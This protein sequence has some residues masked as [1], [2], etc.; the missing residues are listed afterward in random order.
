MIHITK[1]EVELALAAVGAGWLAHKI[2]TMVDL[3]V[4]K[5]KA[6]AAA[7]KTPVVTPAAVVVKPVTPA[8]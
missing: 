6:V 5:A 7:L 1:E 4:A 3:V 2:Y 8:K